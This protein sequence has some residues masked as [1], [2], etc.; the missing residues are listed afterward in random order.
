M[1]SRE[2]WLCWTGAS[3]ICDDD[4]GEPK[5]WKT[6]RVRGR[7]NPG[8]KASI[9]LPIRDG[10]LTKD[11]HLCWLWRRSTL[12]RPEAASGYCS[13]NSEKPEDTTT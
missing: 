4:K 13:R 11:R 10:S 3:L 12:R 7:V 2:H 8:T 9:S 5:A 6:E 1:A